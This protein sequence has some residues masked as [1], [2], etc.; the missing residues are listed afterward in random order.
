MMPAS[1]VSGPGISILGDKRALDCHCLPGPEQAVLVSFQVSDLSQHVGF[2]HP[3]DKET[4]ALGIFLCIYFM[5]NFFP[6]HK[7][8]P[9]S[10]S[11]AV[12][13]PS[14]T[15]GPVWFRG[16]LPLF[17]EDHPD[18]AGELSGGEST[19]QFCRCRGTGWVLCSSGKVL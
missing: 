12:S 16:N 11:S 9:P 2:P 5:F 15:T 18:V 10:L 3:V 1:Q 7:F 17:W 19:P 4:N 6:H 8:V 14:L 13:F